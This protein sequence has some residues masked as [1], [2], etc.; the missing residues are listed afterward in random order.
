MS[1]TWER[2]VIHSL[3]KGQAM[4]CHK[5][6]KHHQGGE[7]REHR[8]RHQR[9]ATLNEPY[10]KHFHW[11]LKDEQEFLGNEKVIQVEQNMLAGG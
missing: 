10:R 8:W 11:V 3:F 9:G 2:T 5:V 1:F 4:S 6:K 7:S